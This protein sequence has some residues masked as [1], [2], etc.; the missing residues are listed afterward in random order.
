MDKPIW[1][2]REEK[3]EQIIVDEETGKLYKLVKYLDGDDSYLVLNDCHCCFV[4]SIHL[5]E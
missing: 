1:V 4:D 3:S 2:F 5:G